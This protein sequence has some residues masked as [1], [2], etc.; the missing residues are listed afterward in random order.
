MLRKTKFFILFFL[1]LLSVTAQF[2]GTSVMPLKETRNIFGG[3][4]NDS[5][6]SV[7]KTS[8]GGYIIAGLS[9]SNDG[10]VSGNH[11]N[12]DFWVVK[13][14]KTGNIEWSKT[15]GG[16]GQ[17][18]ANS[19]IETTD[20]GYAVAGS[21]S[22]NDGNVSGN[23]GGTSDIWVIKLNNVGTLQ[24]QK[25]FGGTSADLAYS[26]IQTSDG[27]YTIAG[28]TNSNDGDVSGNHGS[29]YFWV[30]KLS[31][32]GTLQWQKTFGGTDDDLVRSIILNSDGS[33]T[34]A[35]RSRSNDGDVSGNHGGASDIWVI[36]INNVG[37]LQWQKTFG[38]TSSDIVYSIIQ[39]SD[40]GYAVAGTTQSNNG[41]VSGNHGLFDSW[42]IKISG[43][44]T[45]QWQKTFGG[46]SY[47]SAYSIIQTSDGGYT[48]AGTTQSSDGDLSVNYG[49]VDIW[50]I[51][52][53]NMGA[54]QWQKVFGGTNTDYAYSVI[55]YQNGYLISGE[56]NSDNGDIVGPADSLL[57][58][59]ILNLDS[60]GNIIRLYED[61]AP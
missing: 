9:S 1:G 18:I 33:Y 17:D 50:V 32:I 58:A 20:G 29:Y 42:V 46:T 51:K 44:G 19:I 24:W 43:T 57:D 59:F 14:N 48:I 28:H 3:T 4:Q 60:N 26:L 8:D 39:T 6:Y 5:A 52:I 12:E 45:L 31:S 27:G 34:L 30:I 37:T 54:L 41:N 35:G 61:T 10:D 38:G 7:A 2:P 15:F 16:T 36:K 47:D 23:H 11:G 49:D 53:N 56:S 55:S 22:S 21:S 13:F 40:G 25:T